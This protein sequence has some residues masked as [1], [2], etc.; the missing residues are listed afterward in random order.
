MIINKHVMRSTNEK[1]VLQ[2]VINEGP[3]SRSQISRNLSLNKVT[4][5]DIY[6]QLL[7]TQFIKKIGCGVST[8][9]GGRKPVMA[10][11]NVNYG[12]VAS[13]DM[14]ADAVKLMYSRLNGKILHFQSF[15]TSDMTLTDVI[16]LIEDQL[17]NVDDYGTIHGLMGVAIALDGIIYENKI[18]KTP[19]KGLTHFDLAKYLRDKL[20]IPVVLEKKANLTA[21]FERDF[22]DNEI[23]DNVVSVVVRDQIHAGIVADSRLYSGHE[24]EAGEV[25]TA[26]LE[27]RHVEDHLASVND[28][29]S[30]K[31]LW[32]RLKAI[33]HVERLD[34]TT[35]KHDYIN[36][37]PE[38]TKVFDDF[39]YYLSKVI[40]NV[41]TAFAPDVVVLNTTVLEILPQLLTNV[42]ESTAKLTSPSRQVPI[43]ATKNVQSAALL[44]GASVIIHQAL[45]LESLKMQFS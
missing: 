21:V 4:V 25:G 11:L 13:I 30:E 27:D 2:Q 20:R 3:I 31:A 16:D 19:I 29:A 14:T 1:Q 10:E 5:S 8:K 42:R 32:A 6:N 7:R 28:Y 15:K 41:S 24:G 18:L 44:G 39:V 12:F 17:R 26:L 35:V 34:L 45:G 23:F 36:H 43:I 38:V 37:D 33:K 22:H 9:N 40:A